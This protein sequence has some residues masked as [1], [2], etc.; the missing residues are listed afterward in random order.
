MLSSQVTAVLQRCP[1]AG[2]ALQLRNNTNPED[3]AHMTHATDPRESFAVWPAAFL[4][5]N[6]FFKFKIKTVC[7]VRRVTST[8]TSPALPQLPIWPIH[9]LT[10]APTREC[11]EF[12][13][14]PLAADLE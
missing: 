3:Y 14:M 4:S 1:S 13:T 11:I 5:G 6:W 7:L 9:S 8:L 10:T 12:F 2:H